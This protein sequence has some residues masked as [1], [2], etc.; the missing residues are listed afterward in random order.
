[1][2]RIVV[3]YYF[4]DLLTNL[5]K[6]REN[7][8]NYDTIDD[9]TKTKITFWLRYVHIAKKMVYNVLLVLI[10]LTALKAVLGRD[11]LVESWIPNKYYIGLH[12]LQIIQCIFIF[13]AVYLNAGFETL[14]MALCIDL[15]IQLCILNYHLK[16]TNFLEDEDVLKTCIKQHKFL[17][18]FGKDLRRL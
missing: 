12:T 16:T 3:I 13:L 4:R 1:M 15:I 10:T 14:M 17:I 7:F 8:W 2:L 11:L 5:V 9:E 18:Q 6:Q